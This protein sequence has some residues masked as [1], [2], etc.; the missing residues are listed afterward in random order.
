LPWHLADDDFAL[1]RLLAGGFHFALIVYD[2]RLGIS[3]LHSMPPESL[4]QRLALARIYFRKWP[5]QIALASFFSHAAFHGHRRKQT[6]QIFAIKFGEKL[7]QQADHGECHFSIC[8]FEEI[9]PPTL[10]PSIQMHY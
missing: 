5:L 4:K 2:A 1:R 7:L 6:T 10:T 9:S 3:R 8:L